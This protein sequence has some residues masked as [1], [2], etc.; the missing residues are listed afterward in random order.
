MGWCEALLYII[1][2]EG[3]AEGKEEDNELRATCILDVELGPMDVGGECAVQALRCMASWGC[4][5][6]GA[7]A[8]NIRGRMEGK[9]GQRRQRRRAQKRPRD[10]RLARAKRSVSADGRAREREKARERR[11]R[12]AAE[13]CGRWS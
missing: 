4:W 11:Q 2:C 9:R 8:V 5:A 1:G 6:R 7:G 13:M 12:L 10:V 3:E